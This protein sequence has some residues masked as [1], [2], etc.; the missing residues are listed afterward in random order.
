MQQLWLMTFCDGG[1]LYD[2]IM[3]CDGT[4]ELRSH[5]W[6]EERVGVTT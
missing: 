5:G 1:Y 4:T 3:N 2:E 6:T